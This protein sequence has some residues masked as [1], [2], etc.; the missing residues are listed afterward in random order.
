MDRSEA[1][2]MIAE[3]RA[4]TT[5]LKNVSS[6]DERIDLLER[7]HDL[8]TRVAREKRAH[9]LEARDK[10]THDRAQLTKQ[11]DALGTV[12]HVAGQGGDDLAS[13]ILGAGWNRKSRPSVT[14]PN[15]TAL[16]VETKSGIEGTVMDALPSRYAATSLGLDDRYVFPRFG[17]VG[18]SSDSTSV[19]SYRQKSRSLAAPETMIRDIAEE[20]TKSSTSTISEPVAVALHQIASISDRIANVLL[21]NAGFRSW[22]NTGLLAAYRAALDWH[23]VTEIAAAGIGAGSNEAS[24][25]EAILES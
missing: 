1:A 13:A 7:P 18:V 19:A 16:N 17:T 14:I 6:H 8:E 20:T 10:R 11:L 12:A 21:D 3:A 2:S 24:P 9:E 15:T 23:I 25:Y 4:I 22:V 5:E